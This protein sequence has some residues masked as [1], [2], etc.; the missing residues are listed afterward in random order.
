MATETFTERMQEK[1]LG[2][3]ANY[4]WPLGGSSFSS[5]GGNAQIAIAVR[6]RF[7]S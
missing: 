4:L 3:Q 6:V 7:A 5:R 1:T 2:L